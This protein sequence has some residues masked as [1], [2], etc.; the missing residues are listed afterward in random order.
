VVV[1]TVHGR[2]AFTFAELKAPGRLFSIPQVPH[3]P[4]CS[5]IRGWSSGS[6]ARRSTWEKWSFNR[7][8]C[9]MS[10]TTSYRYIGAV[11]RVRHRASRCFCPWPSGRAARPPAA[12][13][14]AERRSGLSH[15]G[16]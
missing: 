10:T 1:Q 2:G 14:S 8:D 9:A 4:Y 3:A 12:L 7:S 5:A 6:M 13:G 11:S 15:R 16:R